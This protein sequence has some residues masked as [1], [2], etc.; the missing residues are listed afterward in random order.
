MVVVKILRANLSGK[1]AAAMIKDFQRRAELWYSLRSDYTLPFYGIGK[2]EQNGQ[3]QLYAASP[4]M[5]Y[6]DAVQYHQKYPVP[7]AESLLIALD[8]ARGLL[9]LHEPKRP[10][11]IHLGL[12]TDNILINNSRQGV[13]GGFGLIEAADGS[14]PS[15]Y[16]GFLNEMY[17]FL[18]PE[19][20]MGT[21]THKASADVWAWGMVA[22]Q[23]VGGRIPFYDSNDFRAAV[24]ASGGARPERERYPRIGELPDRDAFWQLLEQCWAQDEAKRP[25]MDEV[26]LR[27]KGMSKFDNR[28]KS[29][30]MPL[31]NAPTN[32]GRIAPLILNLN[33]KSDGGVEALESAQGAY[34]C[35]GGTQR[36]E[37]APPLLGRICPDG[38]SRDSPASAEANHAAS[39]RLTRGTRVF[40]SYFL[41]PPSHPSFAP[42]RYFV[43]VTT[44]RVRSR[45]CLRSSAT[46][47]PAIP[48][49]ADWAG[50]ALSDPPTH[51]ERCAGGT[52]MESSSQGSTRLGDLAAMAGLAIATFAPSLV[53]PKPQPEPTAA[54]ISSS[55]VDVVSSS[56]SG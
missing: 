18:A 7:A 47:S 35:D 28:P 2:L 12:C 36:A 21:P 41:C 32:Y 14:P 37:D 43:V 25:T 10:P 42:R 33:K 50:P 8:A 6:G 46:P 56:S 53:T 9:Y 13:L 34:E 29:L 52:T 55:M 3:T 51:R 27:T 22:L 44:C 40:L 4:Y 48:A 39:A 26:V 11:I 16:P 19:Q 15:N 54:S 49:V 24:L 31:T 17:R 20:V 23:L 1:D 38:A 5:K 30:P 45:T